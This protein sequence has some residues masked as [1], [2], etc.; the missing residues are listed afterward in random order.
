MYDLF[1]ARAGGSDLRGEIGET[2]RAIADDSGESTKSSIGHQ[3][4]FDDAAEDVW[5]D[6]AAAKQE[7]ALFAGEFFEFSG[8]RCRQRRGGGSFDDAFFQ[9]D[10]PQNRNCNLFFGDGDR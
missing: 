1:N 7:H 5:I 3:T 8:E 6:V 10:E 9:F 2:A 4:A